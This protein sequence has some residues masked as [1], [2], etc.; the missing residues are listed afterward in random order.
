MWSAVLPVAL[1]RGWPESFTSP[2]PR[3][4][5]DYY[6]PFWVIGDRLSIGAQLSRHLLHEVLERRCGLDLAMARLR[7]ELEV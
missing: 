4:Q 3:P 5:G 2:A 1:W 6:L 7:T